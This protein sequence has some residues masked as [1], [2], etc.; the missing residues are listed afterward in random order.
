[1]KLAQG[2]KLKY[3]SEKKVLIALSGGIDSAVSAYLLLKQGYTVEAAFMK[4]WSSTT[5]LLKNEC[6]WLQ[7]RQDALRVAAFL[8]IPLHTLDF[9]KQY[10]KNV[11]GYFFKEYKAGRTP[12]PDVMCNKEVKFKLLYSWA[13]KNGF[14]YLA[15]GHYAQVVN[16]LKIRDYSKRAD[17]NLKSINSNLVRSADEFK[18]QTYFIY[19]IKTEQLPHILFPIG[20]MKKTEVRKLAQ[21][22]KLP[23][24]DKKESMGLCF[25]GKVRLKEFLE[26]KLKPKK[27][28]IVL[29]EEGG[30]V[31]GRGHSKT[32]G[33][34]LNPIPHTLGFH[35]GL[36]NYTIGQRQGIKVGGGGPYYVVK[37]DL[38]TNT[39]YVTNNP[40]DKALE[41][42]VIEI[43]SV[44]WI[45]KQGGRIEGR[46]NNKTRGRTLNPIPYTLLGRF[47]HQGDLVPLTITPIQKGHY[48][49][50]F[51]KPQKAIASGQSL[52]L[53][54]GKECVGGGVIV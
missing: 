20:G 11:M 15:T 52:V 7:D 18:D 14:D 48:Q 50:T 23:N 10:Q 8:N 40:D 19:N 1:M 54:K 53:Y 41:T 44:N 17:L 6:P 36:Y 31:E 13:M 37:K 2:K 28:K 4:N 25:V 12:N 38:K 46:G 30:R 45:G 33:Y 22:I 35:Q 26:Q 29:F 42:K 34:T 3:K 39:L 16:R 27:G 49:V 21:K 51:K 47:R 5:G 32:R 24:A 43:H 9:E